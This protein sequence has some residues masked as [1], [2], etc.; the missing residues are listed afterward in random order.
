[1]KYKWLIKQLYELIQTDM[2]RGI[3]KLPSENELCKTYK[4]SRQTVRLALSYLEEEGV[5]EKRKGSGTYITGLLRDTGKNTIGILIPNDQEYYYPQLINDIT[6]TASQLGFQTKIFL[7][8]NDRAVEREILQSLISEPLRGLL[9]EGCKSALPNPNISLYQRILK[10]GTSIIFMRNSYDELA[11]LCPCIKENNYAGS[12]MLV[13]HFIAKGH[14]RIGGVFQ[15]DTQQGIERYRGFMDTILSHDL[16]YNDSHIAY[17]DT[18]QLQQLEQNKDISFIQKMIQT[19]FSDCTAIVCQN[20]EIAYWL[21]KEL[22]RAGYQLPQDMALASFDQTYFC[23][24][25]SPILTSL[26]IRPNKIGIIATRLLI[27][28]LKGLPVTTQEIPWK[29]H[30]KPSSDFIL[31]D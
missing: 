17:F 10:K 29:L 31:N 2:K 24:S 7:T 14:S 30:I 23:E 18:N 22:Q 19:S 9:V 1:M 27:D 8:G 25:C 12:Q 28:M 20:D 5:I 16:F 13:E 4:V 15:I 11:A 21:Q 26:S 6:T 3:A